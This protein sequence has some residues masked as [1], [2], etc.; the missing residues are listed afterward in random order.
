MRLG[1]LFVEFLRDV[2]FRAELAATNGA[3]DVMLTTEAHIP[4]ASADNF[5]T[6]VAT[7][8]DHHVF[9]KVRIIIDANHPAS[10]FVLRVTPRCYE[11]P[12]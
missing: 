8:T 6:P 5:T 12:R 9:V 11:R 2:S 1:A 7:V 4:A 3:R 10:S